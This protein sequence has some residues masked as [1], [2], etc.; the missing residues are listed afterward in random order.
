M[1]FSNENFSEVN[2]KQSL[3][4]SGAHSSFKKEGRSPTVCTFGVSFLDDA[5][6]ILPSSFM[7]VGAGTGV[8][9]TQLGLNIA[10]ENASC[11]RK[12]FGLFLEAGLNEIED[13]VKF[14]L[15]AA[16][17]FKNRGGEEIRD[18]R[19][20]QY[21]AGRL[22]DLVERFEDEINAGISSEPSNFT[23]FK[24]KKQFCVE[25]LLKVKDRALAAGAE[26]LIIDHIHH[27]D[28]DSEEETRALTE[29]IMVCEQTT[30]IDELPVILFAQF[31]KDA[32]G[33]AK[34]FKDISDFHGTASLTR[35][36]TDAVIITAGES[37][38]DGMFETFMHIPKSRYGQVRGAA[39][40][41]H[42][43]MKEQGYVEK[44][45]LGKTISDKF[46]TA[47]KI[48]HWAKNHRDGLR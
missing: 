48:P 28:Y 5:L 9:K 18:I 3:S 17:F 33:K 26:L 4:E 38:G 29:I 10:R 2:W 35:T 6:L 14:E 32:G 22:D 40:A 37:R 11:G 13:R 31:R 44:Y 1:V 23:L 39:A 46:E 27:F 12:V 47:I 34:K 30:Q 21:L 36:P 20:N 16:A 19:F 24:R 15:L 8:G 43:S 25:D 41:L 42:F 45:T 7:V